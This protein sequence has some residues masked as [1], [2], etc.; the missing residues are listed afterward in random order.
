MTELSK[1]LIKEVEN[2]EFLLI[3]KLADFV[4]DK[5]L[6][7]KKVKKVIVEVDKPGAI[8]FSESVS[9]TVSGEN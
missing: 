7:D 9:L 6:E 8:R 5:V 4:L 3:E 2:T 1:A